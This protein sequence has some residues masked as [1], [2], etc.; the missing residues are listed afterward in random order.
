V[1]VAH[2]V[3]LLDVS[4]G[5]DG[6]LQVVQIEKHTDQENQFTTH[7]RISILHY[8]PHFKLALAGAHLG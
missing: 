5:E 4:H 2:E 6:Q 8:D 1:S 7:A 3:Q